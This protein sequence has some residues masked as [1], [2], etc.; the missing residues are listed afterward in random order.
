MSEQITGL[1]IFRWPEQGPDWSYPISLDGN[2]FARQLALFMI[3]KTQFRAPNSL[4]AMLQKFAAC[5]R[6]LMP[7]A[8]YD[9]PKLINIAANRVQD[10]FFNRAGQVSPGYLL[11][12]FNEGYVIDFASIA[13]HS[14][15]SV[16]IEYELPLVRRG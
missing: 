3:R 7:G 13:S 12:K 8:C 14:F 10:E 6:K 16:H 11:E 1:K 5:I 15:D 9:K 2:I 4:E